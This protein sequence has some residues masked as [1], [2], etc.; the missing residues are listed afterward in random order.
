[1]ADRDCN[2]GRSL[3][4]RTAINVLRKNGIAVDTEGELTDATPLPMVQKE[5]SPLIPEDAPDTTAPDPR[6]YHMTEDDY[7]TLRQVR[8]TLGMMTAL[9]CEGGNTDGMFGEDLALTMGF[10]RDTLDRVLENFRGSP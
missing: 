5:G 10:L 7:W 9:A 6:P 8:S 2:R 4:E 1:M 3:D